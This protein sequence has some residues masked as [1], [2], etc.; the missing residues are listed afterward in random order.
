MK[1]VVLLIIFTL[2][3]SLK[4]FSQCACCGSTSGFSGGESTPGAYPI[5]K[6]NWMVETYADYRTFNGISNEKK[7]IELGV[8]TSTAMTI[9]NIGIGMVGLRYGI[10]NRTILLVQQ[11]FFLI[12][13]SDLTSKT[14]GDLLTLINYML[15]NKSSLVID[16]QGGMEWPTGQIVGFSNGSS[17]STG[18]GSFDPVT[19][20]SIKKP[21][22]QAYVRGSA[23]F[24]YTTRGYNEVNFGNFFSH[25]LNYTYFITKTNAVCSPDS[26]KK[27]KALVS[28]NT[29]VSGE[30]ARMQMKNNA[31]IENTGSYVS[32]AALGIAITYNGF[33]VPVSVSIPF[34]QHYHGEQ[35][36]THYRLRIGLTKT[37]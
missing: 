4:G 20:L 17:V 13:A 36:I 31:Y 5:G 27:E 12:N 15:M 19:G 23:F 9:K 1:P 24:K 7:T 2:F 26:L 29:Q 3:T 10:T 14:T 28:I 6:N 35:N 33:T 22:K 16:L 25:T 18:S 11:P 32:L 37:F 30:W 34:Y 21:F 8:S